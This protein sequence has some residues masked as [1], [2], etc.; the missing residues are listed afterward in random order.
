MFPSAFSLIDPARRVLANITSAQWTGALVPFLSAA[1]FTALF[2]RW[3]MSRLYLPVGRLRDF[4]R[5]RSGSDWDFL[6]VR[7]FGEDM[8]VFRRHASSVR[9]RHQEEKGEE[10]L[11]AVQRLCPHASGDLSEGDIE[12]IPCKVWSKRPDSII[13]ISGNTNKRESQLLAAPE[14]IL[15]LPQS[16][17]STSF[18]S[19]VSEEPSGPEDNAPRSINLSPDDIVAGKVL[20]RSTFLVCPLHSYVFEVETGACVWD[21]SFQ[22]PPLT[23]GLRTARVLCVLGWVFLQAPQPPALRADAG[24]SNQKDAD[25]IQMDLVA[26]VMDR[27]GLG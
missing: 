10:K 15:S 18:H 25:A 2:L 6:N 26:K 8:T 23:R 22:Q 11:I 4:R 9:Y 5:C 27:G 21:P 1:A 14:K 7:I 24:I 19:A 16:S 12:D 3:G 20:G 13:F 17:S